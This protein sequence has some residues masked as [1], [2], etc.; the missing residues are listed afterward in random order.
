MGASWCTLCDIL[1]TFHLSECFGKDD[2]GLANGKSENK[3][4]MSFGL[5][6]RSAKPSERSSA[7]GFS[8]I[9]PTTGLELGQSS[10]Y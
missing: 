5:H 1:L 7:L 8:Q 10:K 6:V 9:H 2:F 4:E 3:A